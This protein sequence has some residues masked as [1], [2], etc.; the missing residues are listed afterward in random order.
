MIW[1]TDNASHKILHIQIECEKFQDILWDI[2]GP[3][4]IVM[5]LNNIMKIQKY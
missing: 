3:M 5:D 4:N 2:V 1:G